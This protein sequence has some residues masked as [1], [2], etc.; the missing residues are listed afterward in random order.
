MIFA[1][2]RHGR[3]ELWEVKA[4]PLGR[5]GG[6]ARVGNH[7]SEAITEQDTHGLRHAA[8]RYFFH[9]PGEVGATLETDHGAQRAAGPAAV[10]PLAAR[11]E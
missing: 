6:P 11:T 8:I 1:P 2:Y 3:D 9:P 4:E 7:G 10:P 5:F